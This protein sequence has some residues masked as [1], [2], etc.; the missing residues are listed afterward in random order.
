[1]QVIAYQML[2]ELILQAA[3]TLPT[4]TTEINHHIRMC[5]EKPIFEDLHARYMV[6]LKAWFAP[7]EIP[8]YHKASNIIFLYES[9][10]HYNLE[11]SIVFSSPSLT[12]KT[13][14]I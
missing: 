2:K 11:F 4:D 13:K 12:F 7:Y 9:R 10:N 3:E 1:M 6:P 5:L 8:D 14:I